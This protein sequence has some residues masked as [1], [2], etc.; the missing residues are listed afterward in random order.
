MVVESYGV[1]QLSDLSMHIYSERSKYVQAQSYKACIY[2]FVFPARIP[3][4]SFPFISSL[5]VKGRI[6]VRQYTFQSYGIYGG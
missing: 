2:I 3:V 6:Y 4:K 5:I 1:D